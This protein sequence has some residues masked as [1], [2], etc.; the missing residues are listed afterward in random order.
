MP[1]RQIPVREGVQL[2][3]G[4]TLVF[5]M[6][7]GMSLFDAFAIAGTTAAANYCDGYRVTCG[8]CKRLITDCLGPAECIQ[9]RQAM[10]EAI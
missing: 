9:F 1:R 5:P 2:I 6:P 7:P 4:H 10:E 3:G 8:A